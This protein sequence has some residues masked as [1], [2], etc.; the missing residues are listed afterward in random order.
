MKIRIHLVAAGLALVMA[1]APVHADDYPSRPIR[2]VAPFAPGGITDLMARAV[3]TRLSADLGQPVVVENRAGA[4]GIIGANMVARA[5]ADGYTLLMGN[6]S[7]LAINSAMIKD[8]SYDPVRSFTPVSMV[9]IQPLIVAVSPNTPAASMEQLVALAKS[10]PGE[11]FYGTSG[12]SYQ[13]VTEAFSA[14]LGIKMT[15]VPYKGSAPAIEALL[16]G[17]IN[18]MFD[19]FS[20]LYGQVKAGKVKALALTTRTRSAIAPE[21]PTV[22]ETVLPDFNASSWQGIVAPAGTPQPVVAKLNQAIT[23]ALGTDEIKAQFARQGVE[24]AP[25][26]P[27]AFGQY[28]SQEKQRWQQ[29]ANAA[30]I[31][32]Q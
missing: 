5:E 31:Q 19:P 18:V 15:H 28:I 21:L 32:P 4:S 6:I 9:A 10:K 16:G 25:S 3:A 27:E 22:S 11:L 30:G 23:R 2:L 7:T 12:A 1:G 26:T 13:L 8:M 14:A 20:T 24:P 17:Q 29:V